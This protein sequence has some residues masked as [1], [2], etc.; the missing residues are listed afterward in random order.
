MFIRTPVVTPPL[1]E[2]V[3]DAEWQA[4]VDLAACYRIAALFGMTA[5]IY[6]QGE[7]WPM[8][9]GPEMAELGVG[10]VGP[11]RGD[12]VV[13]HRMILETAWIRAH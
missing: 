4:R 8:I 5:L 11:F 13:Y 3:T 1:R 10:A 2:R 12:A 9:V 7:Q 6:T